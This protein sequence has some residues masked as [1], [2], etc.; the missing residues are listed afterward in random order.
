TNNSHFVDKNYLVR[1]HNPDGRAVQKELGLSDF[2]NFYQLCSYTPAR[3]M[4]K[5]QGEPMLSWFLEEMNE[6]SKTPALVVS[7]YAKLIR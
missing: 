5:N 3:D 2:I 1:Y 4:L 6:Q 7:K